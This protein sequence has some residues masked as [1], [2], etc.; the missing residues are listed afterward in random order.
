MRWLTD[1]Q[2]GS[3]PKKKL[4]LKDAFLTAAELLPTGI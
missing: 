1:G 2:F 4:Q 3:G